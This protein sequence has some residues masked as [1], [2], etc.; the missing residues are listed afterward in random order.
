MESLII[1]AQDQALNM[2]YHQKNIMK[3]PTDSKRRMCY[4][5]EEHIK[6]TVMGCTKLAPPE[7]SNIYNKVSGY[8]HWTIRKQMWLQATNRYYEHTPERVI[9]IKGTT[10][11]WD[12][13]VVTD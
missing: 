9:N 4:N 6:H 11:M 13:P 2:R 8:I 1:A 12:A 3:Q 7:Y 5:A 10:I